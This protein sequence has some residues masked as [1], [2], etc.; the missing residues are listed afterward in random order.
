MSA[1]WFKV[2]GL[3]GVWSIIWLPIALLV[4]R[5]INW[6]PREPLEPK[7]KLI[8]L[9]SLYILVPGI[10]IWKV[11]TEFLTFADLG[12]SLNPSDLRYVLLGLGASLASLILVFSLESASNLIIWR[13]QNLRQIKSLLLPILSLSLLISLVEELIF[14]GYIF[15]TLLADNSFWLAAIASSAIFAALHLIWERKQTWPQLPGLWLMGMVLVAAR[16]FT[17][18]TICLAVGLHAGWIWG[19]TCL[20]S[21]DLL[22]YEHQDHWFTGMKQQPLAGMAGIMCLGM[23][24][25]G[26]WIFNLLSNQ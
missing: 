8:L 6:Q 26:I 13:W 2:F 9:A 11:K 7:Q 1:S 18:D 15:I 12:L 14:R 16:V 23:T 21:A 22:T 19:L 10:I 25:L 20:D 4:S 24:G 5:L 3:L 17:N